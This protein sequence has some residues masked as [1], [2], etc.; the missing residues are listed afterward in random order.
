[1]ATYTDATAIAAYL[2]VT[3]TPEQTTAAGQVAE[4]VTAFIDRYTGRSW[5]GTSPVTAEW[6]PLVARYDDGAETTWPTVYLRQRPSVAVTA[7]V[8][9]SGGPPATPTTLDPSQYELVDPQSGVLRL[10]LSGTGFDA[11][12][13]PVVA[14]VDYTYAD[15]VPPDIALASTMMAAAEMARQLA[16]AGSAAFSAAHPELD[17]LKSVA[18]GQNDV[19]IS[20]ADSASAASAGG[21]AASAS[22]AP[23]GSAA[24]TILDSYRRVVLA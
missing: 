21:A 4:A 13:H 17:G 12:G 7:V 16:I 15:A 9:R 10:A 2:G 8:L 19:N 6:L 14:L 18:V 23:P 1:M 20:L 24:R 3:F 11:Y 5:Q 22:L